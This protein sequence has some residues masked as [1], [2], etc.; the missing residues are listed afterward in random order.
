MWGKSRV[1]DRMKE[2]TILFILKKLSCRPHD[3]KKW[4]YKTKEW[5]HLSF[6]MIPKFSWPFH[7]QGRESME[8]VE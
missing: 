8:R 5:G 6:Y 7:P 4:Q 3:L 2:K 1:R